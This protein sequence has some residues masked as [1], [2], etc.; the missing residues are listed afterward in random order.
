MGIDVPSDRGFAV[1]DST[2]H[3][4]ETPEEKHDRVTKILERNSAPPTRCIGCGEVIFSHQTVIKTQHGSY[5]GEPKK[6]VEG[7]DDEDIP[8]WQK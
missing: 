4:E 3:W 2:A 7:R 5:H 6:C 1:N 8:W